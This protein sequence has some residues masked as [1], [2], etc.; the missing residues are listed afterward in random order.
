M[1]EYEI[2]HVFARTEKCLEKAK[3]ELKRFEIDYDIRYELNEKIKES[4][5]ILSPHGKFFGLNG[6]EVLID[7]LSCDGQEMD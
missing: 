4:L 1:E 2:I 7:C 5:A 6:L 3:R